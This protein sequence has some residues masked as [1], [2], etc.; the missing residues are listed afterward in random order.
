MSKKK[1][2]KYED[3]HDTIEGIEYKMC[4]KC[5]VWFVMN[6]RFFKV[7]PGQKDGFSSKCRSCQ[8]EYNHN[9]YM[10]NREK[11]IANSKKWQAENPD[12]V[13]KY[14]RKQNEERNPHRIKYKRE[15]AKLSRERGHVKRWC[16]ENP[17][18]VKF[19][20]DKRQ[21]KNHKINKTE[22]NNCK[23]YFNYTCAYCGLHISEHY[24]T[25][26]GITK[27]GDFHKE[28]VD[29]EG[30]DDLSNC[31]PSCR[32]CNDRKWKFPLEMWYNEDN[33]RY[34]QERYDKIIQWI[35]EDYKQYVEEYIHKR[36]YTKRS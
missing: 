25:R 14:W 34:S 13:E 30:L 31:V 29:N 15:Q 18:R 23:K 1:Y 3:C 2:I 27:L 21:H 20:M 22:W 19:Y 33:E 5:L 26:N 35:T 32:S 17:D 4:K 8:E 7:Q 10:R 36:K 12:K 16:Q 11:E 6:E 28:H 24:Y 9:R